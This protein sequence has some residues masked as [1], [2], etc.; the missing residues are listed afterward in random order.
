MAKT[1]IFVTAGSVAAPTGFNLDSQTMRIHDMQTSEN[2]TSYQGTAFAIFLG[3]GTEVLDV[4]ITGYP[5]KGTS[6]SNPGFGSMNGTV[7]AQGGAGV[8]TADAGCTF[9]GSFLIDDISMDHS[10]LIAGAKTS[11]GMKPSAEITVAW[12]AS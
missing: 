8:L 9:T 12:A 3:S 6:A 5:F 10:R 2:I 4:S 1:R 11:W 7:G